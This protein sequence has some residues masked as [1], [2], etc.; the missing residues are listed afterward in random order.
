MQFDKIMTEKIYIKFFGFNMQS[1]PSDTTSLL[2]IGL[3]II[4][5][6]PKS[7]RQRREKEKPDYAGIKAEF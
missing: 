5:G 6:A 7:L 4:S 2:R 3:N 1:S